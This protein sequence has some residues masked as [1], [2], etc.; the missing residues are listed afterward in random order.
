MAFKFNGIL[1]FNGDQA[2]R[3]M[4]R[5]GR[6]VKKLRKSFGSL[7]QSMGGISAGVRASAIA[8]SPFALAMGK[9]ISLGSQFESQLST[10]ESVI[11]GTTKEMKDLNDAT[12]TLGITTK[13]TATE[14]ARGAEFLVRAGFSAKQ[15]AA[16]LP[17][18]L[19][20]AAAAGTDLALTTD[21]V[22]RNLGAFGLAAEKAGDVADTLTVVTQL[23]N[24]E[25]GQLG[26]AMR[27]AAVA[28][29]PAGFTFAE[30]AASMGVLANAGVKGTLAGTAFKNALAKL[31]KPSKEAI[32][33]FGGRDGLD[34]AI[35]RM[36]DGVQK[37]RPLE[38]IMANIAVVARK[39]KNKMQVL[40][41]AFEILGLRGATTFNA[42][43][44]SFQKTTKLTTKNFESIKLGAKL[45]GEEMTA[46]LGESIPFLVALRLASIGAKGA[47][48]KAAKIRLDNVIGQF[49]LL[50]SAASGVSLEIN[51]LVKNP[52]Q[53][54]L[55]KGADFLSVLAFGFAK[56]RNEGKLTQEQLAA[57][58]NTQFADLIDKTTEFATGFIEGFDQL[59]I[60]AKE[61]FAQIKQ[62][63]E[64]IL[65][66]TKLTAKEFGNIAAKVL[67]WGA[68]AAPVLGGIAAAMFILVPIAIGIASV[69]TGIASVISIVGAVVGFIFPGV[70]LTIGA[71]IGPV[72]LIVAAIGLAIGA[73]FLFKD[74][75]IETVTGAFKA[76]TDVFIN[77]SK[78]SFLA[79]GKVIFEAM[80]FPFRAYI[81]MLKGIFT[82]IASLLGDNLLSKIG[83]SKASI[84]SFLAKVPGIDAI[85]KKFGIGE[86]T[87]PSDTSK[88]A[89][90]ISKESSE[91][92]KQSLRRPA[93]VQPPSA[94]SQRPTNVTNITNPQ[95]KV[96]LEVG[97]EGK[98]KGNDIA[99]VVTKAKLRQSNLNGKTVDVEIARTVGQ[100][101]EQLTGL[102]T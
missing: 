78:K 17:G 95:Q 71:V 74:S 102:G 23:T 47:A 94:Q 87:G 28:A 14:S 101:G 32:K 56:V 89:L 52:M 61:T 98:I 68:I 96:V 81:S 44:A 57:L 3:G 80:T 45:A 37:V 35:F 11:T 40:G 91:L 84:S 92:A 29:K 16:A 72:L 34:K 99:L 15:A 63:L 90:D 66:D 20:A 31:A 62:F 50:L 53:A 2:V 67:I 60:T 21:V 26:E 76:V 100:N 9:V 13:F 42:F 73:F 77:P 85:D 38:E 49:T 22:A 24:T 43:A 19:S 86:D 27:Q 48:D 59:K 39:S 58:S 36:V 83:L 6:G 51:D 69:F 55:T 75:V 25:L 7:R 88:K 79:L 4:N 82:G 10:V 33:L 41:K 65:G 5:A 1:R 70:V 64:P 54:L 8:F 97:V 18:V 12:R 30:T 46:G 93:I